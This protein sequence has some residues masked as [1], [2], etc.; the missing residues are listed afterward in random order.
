MA[1][2]AK[3]IHYGPWQIPV[4]VTNCLCPDGNRRNVKLTGEADTF[5]TIPAKLSYRGT[6]VSGYVTQMN[7]TDDPEWDGETVDYIFHPVGK[8]AGI[9]DGSK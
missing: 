8:N 4:R 6:S 7:W 5:F 2:I 1:N 3:I 9:F